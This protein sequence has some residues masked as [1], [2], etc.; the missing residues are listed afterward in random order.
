MTD[1]DTTFHIHRR[2]NARPYRRFAVTAVFD[3]KSPAG[4][5]VVDHDPVVADVT[6]MTTFDTH[7]KTPQ[8]VWSGNT[9]SGMS[10]SAHVLANPGTKALFLTA[11]RNVPKTAVMPHARKK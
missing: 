6:F 4:Y 5:R 7:M 2:F 9:E 8:K 10:Y 11:I 3:P 1:P